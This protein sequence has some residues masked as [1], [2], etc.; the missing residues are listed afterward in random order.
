[1]LVWGGG[2]QDY[3]GNELYAFD[4]QTGTWSRIT[5]PTLIPEGTSPGNFL[6]RD[7]LSNGQPISRHTYDGVEFLDDLNKLWAHGGSMAGEGGATA[8]TW[9]FESSTGWS[10]QM[11]SMDGRANQGHLM[12]A[13][14]YDAPSRRVF[15]H[16]SYMQSYSVDDDVWTTIAGFGEPPLWPRYAIDGDKTAAIDTQRRLFW[17]VGSG[18]VLVW[19][20]ARGMAVTDD[21]VTT[22]GGAYTNVDDVGSYPDQIFESGGGNVYN[23]SAPG[24]DYDPT[25]DALV[26][27]PNRGAPYV[28]DLETREW[29]LGTGT[30]APV[31]ENSGGT[32]GRWRYIRAY[33]VFIL[34]NSVDDNVYF[35]KHTTGCGDDA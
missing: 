23:E 6:N 32:F 5:E 1:M 29:T 8:Q 18:T 35:Y 22:G 17:S 21:W 19:D 15:T 2:H 25:S 14:A 4:L 26:A 20:M 16:S 33:N 31:S 28:L 34:V 27:W 3:W 30:G 12:L 24:L 7:P 13:S 10:R 11:P 9:L